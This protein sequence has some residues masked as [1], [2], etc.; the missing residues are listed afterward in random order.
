MSITVI[1]T[2]RWISL[3]LTFPGVGSITRDRNIHAPV[4]CSEEIAE[5][6]LAK[7]YAKLAVAPQPVEIAPPAGATATGD[8][9]GEPTPLVTFLQAVNAAQTVE[10]LKELG[11]APT[12]ATALLEATPVNEETILQIISAK[13]LNGLI[14][15]LD[16]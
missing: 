8:K 13:T 6:L 4:V 10:E 7:F 11:I 16:D 15:K 9:E 14:A 1:P 3:T 5:R 12:K 2:S